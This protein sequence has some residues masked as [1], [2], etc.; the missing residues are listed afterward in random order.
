MSRKVPKSA[1]RFAAD[2]FS[3]EPHECRQNF[4]EACIIKRSSGRKDGEAHSNEDVCGW[5]DSDDD[6]WRPG[7]ADSRRLQRAFCLFRMTVLKTT[8][9]SAA[10]FSIT[11]GRASPSVPFAAARDSKR[12]A[13]RMVRPTG[14]LS[15]KCVQLVLPVILFPPYFV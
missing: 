14:R 15:L 12:F 13:A 11:D 4:F 2:W 3:R 7:L 9:R 1:S 10:V 6:S 8:Q 5:F